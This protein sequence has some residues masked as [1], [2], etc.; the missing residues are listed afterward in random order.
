MRSFGVAIKAGS[1]KTGVEQTVFEH[2]L[3]SGSDTGVITQMWHAGTR[4]DPRM[5]IYVDSEV[6]ESANS[7]SNNVAID[8]SVS[9][10]HGLAPEDDGA[11]PWQSERFGHTHNM[12]WYNRYQIPFQSKVKI[13]M[14]CNVD[15]PFWFRVAGVENYP[16][17]VGDLQLPSHAKLEIQSFNATVNIND[18]VTLAALNGTAGL[19]TQLNVYVQSSSAYQE[20]C[21]QATLDGSHQWISSGFEDYFLGS[22]F[23]T[24]PN[25][26]LGLA[27]F[28]L[29][30]S[31]TCKGDMPNSLAAYRIHSP[32]P[33]LFTKSLLFQWQPTSD[34]TDQCNYK[35]PPTTPPSIHGSD[36]TREQGSDS[37]PPTNPVHVQTY[38]W[39]YK[40]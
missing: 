29:T 35:W 24:M 36:R 37:P 13:T 1:C 8:Y 19:L 18:L 40:Y 25:M 26:E 10:A 5:R 28:R 20:G 32:D 27:G 33:L 6:E 39:V 9:L 38:A 15:S 3:S 30:N 22:Y 11:W 4:G 14:T 2:V 12:G 34:H 16:I 23:H 7:E 31:T 21:V 17:I